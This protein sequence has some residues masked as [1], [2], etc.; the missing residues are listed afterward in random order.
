M[1]CSLF[2]KAHQLALIYTQRL[3]LAAQTNRRTDDRLTASEVHCARANMTS[4]IQIQK[5]QIPRSWRPTTDAM[6]A[7]HSPPDHAY[8]C[9]RR[10]LVEIYGLHCH[11][12]LGDVC[13]SSKTILFHRHQAAGR[14]HTRSRPPFHLHSTSPGALFLPSLLSFACLPHDCIVRGQRHKRSSWDLEIQWVRMSI[15]PFNR[16][17]VFKTVSDWP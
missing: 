15:A 12:V 3:T 5:K 9:T 7:F 13:H 2:A 6:P 10:V 1:L 16:N 4:L 14:K 17:T 8:K 11:G